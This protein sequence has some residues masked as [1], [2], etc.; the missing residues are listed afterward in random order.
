MPGVPD[1]TNLYSETAADRMSPNV[2]GALERVY[3]PNRRAHSVSVIDPKT[4]K[5]VDTFKVGVHPQHIV[6]SWDLRCCM[7]PTMPRAA[8]TA[9]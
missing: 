8:P 1:R 2:A 7:P 6:P 9:A 3:V 4:L 5:V